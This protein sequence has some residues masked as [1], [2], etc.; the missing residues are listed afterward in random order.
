M[1]RPHLLNGRY[2]VGKPLHQGGEGKVYLVHDVTQ[3][4]R[5]L[6]L[7]AVDAT[8]G[9]NQTALREEAAL[10]SSL[11][12][13]HLPQVLSWE[14][15]ESGAKLLG[16][17]GQGDVWFFTMPFIDGQDWFTASRSAPLNDRL[18]KALEVAYALDFLHRSGFVH[19][20]VKPTNVLIEGASQKAF[21]VDLGLSVKQ[22]S[23]F[24]DEISGTP[25]F[26][27]PEALSAGELD[28]RSDIYAF[29]LTLYKIIVGR[30]P[31]EGLD[32][33]AVLEGH[34]RGWTLDF[35]ADI[36]P[37]LPNAVIEFLQA[38][39]H[40]EA[41]KRPEQ[42][43][44][45][46][47]AL[48]A[49]LRKDGK[50]CSIAPPLGITP[51]IDRGA[52]FERL[53]QSRASKPRFFVLQGEPG[54]GK[55]QVLHRLFHDQ[56]QR[57]ETAVLLEARGIAKSS[58]AAA[59]SAALGAKTSAAR[60]DETPPPAALVDRLTAPTW[61]L[62]DDVDDASA[63]SWLEDLAFFARLLERTT[64][65]VN[66]IV[67]SK[68]N[69]QGLAWEILILDSLD[70]AGVQEMTERLLGQRTLPDGL[71][72]HLAKGTQGNPQ[73]VRREILHLID[74]KALIWSRGVYRWSSEQSLRD[75]P[76]TA[77][78]DDMTTSLANANPAMQAILKTASIFPNAFTLSD[79]SDLC[80]EP[81]SVGASLRWGLIHN[82]LERQGVHWGFSRATD[83]R[84]LYES[85]S[86]T[87]RQ[88]LHEQR[89]HRLEN[90]SAA[91]AD[92]E[93]ERGHHWR[94]LGQSPKAAAAFEAA[95]QRA[96]DAGQIGLAISY[97]SEAVTLW[98]D[99]PGGVVPRLTL[100]RQLA[101]ASR[102][103]EGLDHLGALERQNLNQEQRLEWHALRLQIYSRLGRYQDAVDVALAH[104]SEMETS[105]KGL[106]RARTA[107][108][109]GQLGSCLTRLGRFDEADQVIKDGL[110]LSRR[111]RDRFG[112]ISMECHHGEWSLQQG[113]FKAA[114][115][116]Y[117]RVLKRL[118]QS[119]RLSGEVRGK[120]LIATV[121]NNLGKIAVAEGKDRAAVE[122]FQQSLEISKALSSTAEECI[123]WIHLGN[124]HYRQ[125][126]YK[127]AESAYQTSLEQCRVLAKR[128]EEAMNLFN[129]G[130]LAYMSGRLAKALDDHEKALRLVNDMGDPAGISNSHLALAIVRLEIGDR[131]AALQTVIA[132][133]E[134]APKD[135]GC[136]QRAYAQVLRGMLKRIE[137]DGPASR[138]HF[139][140]AETH[141]KALGLQHELAQTYMEWAELE[142]IEGSFVEAARYLEASRAL[143]IPLDAQDLLL[144]GKW[145]EAQIEP[146]RALILL[147]EAERD[148]LARGLKNLLWRIY[149]LRASLA[150]QD[151][152]PQTGAAR[153][154]QFLRKA[155]QILDELSY[156]L[157]EPQLEVFWADSRHRLGL[158]LPGPRATYADRSLSEMT[159]R[160]RNEALSRS[161]EQLEDLF[162]INEI[163]NSPMDIDTLLEF[164]LDTAVRLTRAQRGLILLNEGS[165]RFKV[166]CARHLDHRN[167]DAPETAFSYSI[168][169]T[170]VQENRCIMLRDALADERFAHEK[171]IVHLKLR[172]VL[173]VPLRHRD[174]TLGAI[175]LDNTRRRDAFSQDDVRLME[176]VG[177]QAALALE[178]ARLRH[179]LESRLTLQNSELH[180][181]REALKGRYHHSNLIGGASK[182]MREI[183]ALLDKVGH[184]S[185][186]VLIEGESG[187]GKELVARAIHAAGAQSKGPFVAENCAAI[188]P[189]LLES[190]LFGHTKGAF[191]GAHQDH[192]GLFEAADGGTLF[193]DE[194][195]EMSA[196]LQVKLLRALQE[197]EI[198]PVG[199]NYLVKTNVRIIAASNRRLRDL[200]D[201]GHFRKDLYYRL[202][203][204]D[205]TLPPLRERL[206]DLPLLIKHFLAEFSGGQ[207]RL[208]REAENLFA[209]YDWPGNVRELRHTLERLCVTLKAGE[210][211][212]SDLPAELQNAKTPQMPKGTLPFLVAK[213]KFEET[214][215]AELMQ[216]HG[217]N[218]TRA[219]A[220]TGLYRQYL[221]RLLKKYK[222][223]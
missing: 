220:A 157:S 88:N 180:Q 207:V 216:A 36:A 44:P 11:N 109:L 221:H 149:A 95:A 66:V 46:I 217:G 115:Q 196:A 12:H 50:E 89:L 108:F 208:S 192:K 55:T 123:T 125:G 191:T 218:V 78:S 136:F 33:K 56:Q 133:E 181:A 121:L 74:Q 93:A 128:R 65:P 151:N 34:R 152:A 61:I 87:Q 96:Q 25:E 206:E 156:G 176:V 185:M 17:D 189:A 52:V 64:H 148:A 40:P 9:Q 145:I 7:K 147:A 210:V 15:I 4:E 91:D 13:P 132:A 200:V 21:L 164:I 6:A 112:E 80:A 146:Q 107:R 113:F 198:R 172:S 38:A 60:G 20:D 84:T 35:P 195:G 138:E 213:K 193:L 29:A 26:L 186:A 219:A 16:L 71:V 3:G 205:L 140:V 184:T 82:F 127:E 197:G 75:L 39:V 166:P 188:P 41:W 102:F 144:Q 141:F 160:F 2:R 162:R 183:F 94:G 101:S 14:K 130:N 53:R 120:R 129:L 86:K 165:G 134:S 10:L 69:W 83:R 28:A 182:S 67:T 42:L 111:S 118:T 137:G 124:V 199:A 222:I 51:L 211:Q 169:K 70:E 143:A 45:L 97:L 77:S 103:E 223:A 122:H 142:M 1:S 110:L 37:H 194:I 62:I 79:L 59:L 76:M 99:E 73:A 32:F 98:G 163:M 209:N 92:L 114:K 154:S 167:L 171:S 201:K 81:S 68:P 54:T 119:K 126:R 104:R 175:Y 190:I 43:F 215:L 131:K 47:S 22:R 161:F 85:L 72:E 150:G 57:G 158:Q 135:A 105:G 58:L 90:I 8:S 187:T 214:Y 203:G 155:R 19:R 49:H 48:T 63:S 18:A 177:N 179:E 117:R 27:P 202:R 204:I 100:V 5:P 23:Q 159:V 173:A 153:A 178:N 30:L 212:A 31:S 174:R 170:T 139:R 24:A 106:D 168:A 116:T